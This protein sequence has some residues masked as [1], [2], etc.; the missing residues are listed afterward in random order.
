MQLATTD[1][2]CV[3]IPLRACGRRVGDRWEGA[4]WIP[5]A[6]GDVRLC[7][8]VSDADVARLVR[9]LRAVHAAI[10]AM[11]HDG[12]ASLLG[13][14]RA[15]LAQRDAVGWVG[16]WDDDRPEVGIWPLIAAIAVPLI[17]AGI[18]AGVSSTTPG[19]GGGLP[20]GASVTTFT[21]N[22]LN[23]VP[24]PGG[25]SVE[26]VRAYYA[27]RG[28]DRGDDVIPATRTP[29]GMTTGPFVFPNPERIMRDQALAWLLAYSQGYFGRQFQTAAEVPAAVRQAWDLAR[30]NQVPLWRAIG[31]DGPPASPVPVGTQLA[32]GAGGLTVAPESWSQPSTT[33]RD[34]AMAATAALLQGISAAASG[35]GLNGAQAAAGLLQAFAPALSQAAGS[36]PEAAAMI[37]AALRMGAGAAGILGA[38]GG[39]Q[40]AQATQGGQQGTQA[41][42]G[43]PGATNGLAGLAALLGGAQGAQG[44][45]QGAQGLG[46]LLG[47]LLGSGGGGQGLGALLNGLAS[48]QTQP[49]GSTGGLLGTAGLLGAANQL[50]P[51]STAGASSVLDQILGRAASG[52]TSS[53]GAGA[54]S[55]LSQIL[56]GRS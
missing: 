14:I 54:G 13:E 51:G 47:G 8:S 17:T 28:A 52:S 38:Q 35:Q 53:P 49:T 22:P 56:G 16:C 24:R 46:G 7:A 18:Q 50:A 15:Q 45:Q 21:S 26:E 41:T 34:A 3:A 55:L 4:L 43:G 33:A 44:G 48:G 32:H 19:R 29:D 31:L 20:S 12:R 23:E 25:P 36:S 9:G 39:Q 27:Q 11:D 2:R 40:G 37:A 6:G 1:Q 30:S 42:Q 5:T 10:H